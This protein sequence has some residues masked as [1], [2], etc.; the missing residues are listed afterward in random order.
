MKRMINDLRW[1]LFSAV[2]DILLVFSLVESLRNGEYIWLFAAIFG[3]FFKKVPIIIGMYF[4]VNPI[5]ELLVSAPILLHV[6]G[7]TFDL[8]TNI[9]WW[10][11]LTHFMSSVTV[12]LFAAYAMIVIDAYFAE[13]KFTLPVVITFVVMLSLAG[14]ALWEIG[15]YMSDKILGTHEQKGLDDTM[16]DLIVDFV[17]GIIVSFGVSYAIERGGGYEAVKRRVISF[18]NS[19]DSQIWRNRDKK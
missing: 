3:I 7:G 2:T 5:W 10:D 14:G 15:E 6:L 17:G 16:K 8:Y 13:V 11:I 1:K 19:V 12:C 4:H 9:P 18:E